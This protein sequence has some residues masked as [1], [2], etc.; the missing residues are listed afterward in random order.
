MK[1]KLLVLT[2]L[3]SL[4]AQAQITKSEVFTTGTKFA[5][6]PNQCG[7]TIP[8]AEGKLTFCDKIDNLGVVERSYG[9]SDRGVERMLPN[10]F[11]NDEVYVTRNG[12]SIRNEDGTWENIPN[13]AIPPSTP[14]YT[15]IPTIKNGLV[16]PNGK[17]LIQATNAVYGMN[18]YD[19]TL[20][21]I[22][23]IN[24]PNNRYPQQFAYDAVRGLTWILVQAGGGTGARYLFSYDGTELNEI[25]TLPELA[26]SSLN[27]NTANVTYKDNHIYLA[28]NNGLFK[29]D[30]TDYLMSNIVITQ[31]DATSTATLPFDRTLDL[32]FDGNGD[33]WLAQSANNNGD[34]AIVKFDVDIESYQMYQLE[35]ENTPTL[36]HAFQ[37][38]AIDDTG[39]IWAVPTSSSSI[40]QLTFPNDIETWSTTT[41]ADLTTLGVPITYVPNNIYFRNNKFYFTTLDGSSGSNDHFEVI[42]N[43]NDVWYGRN[44][45]EEGN[46][47]QRMNRR[48]TNVLP[49]ANGGVWWF[50]AYDDIVVYRDSDDNHQNI[51][52]A[53]MS[54]SAVVDVDNKAI[55]RGGSPNELRKID[56]PNANSIQ[57]ESFQVNDMKRVADQVWFFDRNNKNIYAYQ[58]DELVTTYNLDEDWYENVFYF[59]AD[60]NGDAWFMQNNTGSLIIKKFDTNTLV[61]TTFDDEVPEVSLSTLRKVVA[62]PNNGV[63][64]IGTLGAIYQEQGVFYPF[65]ASDHPE[66]Y[67]LRDIV[68]DTNGK[69]Y[70]LNNDSATITSIENPTDANPTLLNIDIEGNNTV[71]PSLDHYR[72]D[73][74]TIDSEGSI[75]THASQNVFKLIDEDLASEYIAQPALGVLE[76]EFLSA[77]SLHPNPTSGWV[78]INSS[79][80]IKQVEVYNFLGKKVKAVSNTASINVRDLASGVYILKITIGNKT[81]SK[82]LIKQ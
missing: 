9:L 65:M 57:D 40:Y 75:W 41:S 39:S 13:I 71:L 43:D 68:V 80:L 22:T 5:F 29:M 14:N 63:W 44:D 34:G 7:N 33:L 55:V 1:T 73:A 54:F 16:L 20:K 64:F 4:I 60:D 12:L 49:D 32:Q 62:A 79:Q 50:N 19:R 10:H 27:T 11:N 18:I 38:M 8:E 72:P 35:R 59:A 17:V 26:S 3:F 82:K 37:K 31:Y 66:I 58:N 25:T 52:I 67:N 28:T 21:T 30:V 15:Q 47:S 76:N 56:F 51:D 24:F 53:N 46:L 70:L 2:L 78:I 36:N 45:N 23:S 77:L 6:Y 61:T 69:A 48:F 74:L 81:S 42:I